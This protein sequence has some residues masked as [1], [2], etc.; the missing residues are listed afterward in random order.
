[1]PISRP[2]GD[3]ARGIVARRHQATI[4]TALEARTA[5]QQPLMH[6]AATASATVNGT[7]RGAALAALPSLL[8][9]IAWAIYATWSSSAELVTFNSTS[10]DIGVYLQ[11]LWNT[12]HG[13][14]FQTTLLESNRVHLAEHVALLLPVLSPAFAVVPDARWLFGMQSTM[15]ALAAVPVYLLARRLLGGIA[16]P[17]LFV[18]AY[19]AMP[20]V[21]EIGFDAF[22]PVTWAALPIGFAAYF[23][24][25]DRPR[26]GAALAI[27][28]LPI[29]EETG[30]A[31]LGL[32]LFLLLRAGQRR[33]G[34][35]LA[36]LAVLWLG[37]IAL[38]IMP[39]FHEP[40]TLP[41]PGDIRTVDHFSQLLAH[42]DA[43]IEDFALH[44]VPLAA[45]WLL[46][47]TGG[48]IFLAP[49]VAIID[50][51]QA[52]TLLL[53]DKDGRFR[54]H[55]AAPMLPTIWMASVV[56]LAALG[57]PRLRVFGATLMI[58]GTL[59]CYS[60]D[61]NLP[62]GGDYDPS[63][64]VWSDRAEQM[65]YLVDRVP[66]GASVG[67]SRR[68]LSQLSSRAE[69]YV[70][71]PSYLGKLWPPERRLQAYVLDLTNDGT[72]DALASRQSP[73]RA[74]RPYAIWLSGDA[75]MLLLDRAPEPTTVVDRDVGGLQLHGLDVRRSDGDYDIEAYWQAPDRVGRPLTRVMRLLDASDVTLAELSGLALDDVFPTQEWPAGQVIVERSRLAP[76]R[77]TPTQIEIGWVATSGVVST[78]RLPLV[79]DDR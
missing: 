2:P 39:R 4:I 50:V 65:Q 73:L 23:L 66:A 74:S 6:P 28:A 72:H 45:R 63:D 13:H 38:V 75:G 46:A 1:M 14:P 58:V 60:I 44:R 17:T 49:Q 64:L 54:R 22:Y 21:T 41:A 3:L 77:G 55:W 71:P 35:A 31:V 19:F 61:N 43:I 12:A 24:L 36:L 32:G 8:I 5:A 76:E 20:T 25:T 30:L 27:L 56:G 37:L 69:L 10:R 62:G 42:P 47:P 40:S 52:A 9:G 70:Y 78:V 79:L 51:P 68:V 29:E 67:A 18:A 16:L 33:L 11:M 57:R 59:A 15:L 26:Q 53:A 34:G 7:R 48:L